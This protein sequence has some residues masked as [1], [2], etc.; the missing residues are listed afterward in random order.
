MCEVWLFRSAS[1]Y[2]LGWYGVVSRVV[3]CG[4]DQEDDSEDGEGAAADAA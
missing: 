1:E 4:V 2:W 3:L